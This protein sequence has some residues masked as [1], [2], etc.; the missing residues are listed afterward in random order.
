VLTELYPDKRIRAAL[1]WTDVPD[2]ME[3]SEA[4]LD[5]ALIS[6]TSA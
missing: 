3:I 6:I 4:S 2:L 1:V 5:A